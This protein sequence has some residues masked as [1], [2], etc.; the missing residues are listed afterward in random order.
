[1][2]YQMKRPAEIERLIQGGESSD[3]FVNVSMSLMSNLNMSFEEVK[4]L[5]IPTAIA[6]LKKL[7]QEED[8]IKRG[9]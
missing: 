9:K 6:F 3:V 8:R 2:A 5:P 7:K 1:M 4:E